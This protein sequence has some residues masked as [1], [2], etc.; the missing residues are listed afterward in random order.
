MELD[1]RRDLTY[2]AGSLHAPV[3]IKALDD[4]AFF[5]AQSLERESFLATADL[6]THL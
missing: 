5:A 6:T 2:A 3:V 4:A 1:V